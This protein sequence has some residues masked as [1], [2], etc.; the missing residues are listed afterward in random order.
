MKTNETAKR[1]YIAYGSNLN[2]AQMACR[3]PDARVVDKSE[4]RGFRLAFRGEGRGG[5][6]TVEPCEG[7]TVP[8]LVWELSSDDEASLDRYEGWPY[9]YRKEDFTVELQGAPVTA[10]AYVMNEGKPLSSPDEFYFDTIE[11]GYITADFDTAALRRAAEEP[12]QA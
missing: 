11:E 3:C 4:L 1:L 2:L 5:V 12:E 8:V 9:L 6:A 10:M 7:C